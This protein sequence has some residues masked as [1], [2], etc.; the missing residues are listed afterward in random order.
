MWQFALVQGVLIAFLGAV[1]ASFGPI[2]AD[3]SHWFTRHRG[4]AVAIAASGNYLAGAIWPPIVQHFV[5]TSGWRAT[6]VG[7]GLV[8]AAAMVPARPDA[9]AAAGRAGDHGAAN[10][11]VARVARIV[12]RHAATGAGGR[13]IL[14]LLRRDGDAA[15]AYRRLLQRPGLRRRA[16][17]HHAWR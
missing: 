5:Q 6:Y 12:A 9:A 14:L 7:I 11:I 16:W 15:G 13:R 10:G 2:V 17:R 3:I 1:P 4:I 8:C